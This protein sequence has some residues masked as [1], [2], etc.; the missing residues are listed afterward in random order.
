MKSIRTYKNDNG[1]MDIYLSSG[2]ASLVENKNELTQS[3]KY[4]I[5]SNLGQWFLG[6]DF[7]IP[8]IQDDD[9][10]LL[11]TKGITIDEIETEVLSIVYKRDDVLTAEITSSDL[12][13]TN[14]E[15]E[16]T[17][18]ITTSY[19]DTVELTINPSI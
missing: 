18:E 5:E 16:M 14:R 3:L 10:G 15:A 2:K 19:G 7:G 4:E 8:W 6:T 17:I 9:S 13:E 12:N 1:D 11:D